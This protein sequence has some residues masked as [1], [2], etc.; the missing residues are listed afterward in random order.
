MPHQQGIKTIAQNRKAFHDYFIED[1]VPMDLSDE[2]FAEV[3][4]TFTAEELE[5]LKID[6]V[7]EK[8]EIEQ[9]SSSGAST[10]FNVLGWILLIA[11]FIIA[12]AGANVEVI[13]SSG[14]RT[15]TE[16]EFSFTVFITAFLVYIIYACFCFCAATLFK[17]LRTITN[18]LRRKK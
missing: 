3:C 9:D 6:R 7:A 14:Y 4:K 2:E 8:K 12:I 10:F 16:K 11:G 18:L 13:K 1:K 15:Y 5:K 17:E